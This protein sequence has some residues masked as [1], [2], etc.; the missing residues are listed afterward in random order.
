MPKT[1]IYE[2]IT[3][4]LEILAP[5][6]SIDEK[7]MPE[8]S[9]KQ[10]LTLYRNMM[11]MRLVDEKAL[12]LQRQ[13]RMGTWAPSRGQEAIQAGAAMA[14][15]DDDWI[16]PAFRE[17]GLL[18]LRGVPLKDVYAYWAG[19]GRGAF[20]PD[21]PRILP[22]AVPVG[23]QL[24]HGTGIGIS[25]KLKGEK[26]AALTFAGD[27]ASSEGDFH[28]A[29]NFAGVFKPKTVFLIQNNQW[30][31]STP[32]EKQTAVKSVAQKTHAYGIPGMQVDGNDVFAVYTA[33][34]E[35]MKKARNGE[36]PSLIEA[37]TYR[38]GDH[39]TADDAKKY[40]PQEEVDQ[41]ELKSPLLRMMKYM[42][43]QN[44]WSEDKDDVLRDELTG[45]IEDAVEKWRTADPM[46]PLEMF[47]HMYKVMPQNLR[48]QQ[49]FLKQEV[50][51]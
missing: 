26:A 49:A 19:D 20:N 34:Q 22:T 50:G 16:I 12:N 25:L 14:L 46:S 29:L 5:D 38:M 11:H 28:E 4:R 9:D 35:A 43:H 32:F 40:R 39:T 1:T 6:G 44:L 15:T 10:V 37:M 48:E 2:A 7:L 27:G 42:I 41:W 36:G 13:G 33:V 51:Q 18:L 45:Q 30:A 23:S 21:F 8:L 31:I 17:A 24:L 47:N 3:Q